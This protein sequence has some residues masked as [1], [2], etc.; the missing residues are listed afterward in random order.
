MPEICNS[1]DDNCNG[2]VDEGF[3]ADGDGYSSCGGDCN[4]ANPQIR[5]G[6][7][8]ICNGIDDN[9]NMVIDEG[10]DNDGD[11]YTSCGGDCNDSNPLI[12]P[13]QPE[14]CNGIDD[15]C[16]LSVDE[17]FPDTDG[18][19]LKDCVDPDDD[20][21]GVLDGADCAPLLYSVAHSPGEAINLSVGAAS[22]HD[23]K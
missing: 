1:A 5:P 23:F 11:G 4:D 9:C 6:A 19:G 14:V 15:N 8:E 21:D 17:G 10:F 2:V 13:G 12:G 22:S 16:N 3:D 20:N 18:D 7:T